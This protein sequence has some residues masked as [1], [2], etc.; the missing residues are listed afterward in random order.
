MIDDHV[1]GALS[2]RD[3]LRMIGHTVE[4]ANSGRAGIQT[5]GAFRPDVILCDIGLPGMDGYEVARA[6]RKDPARRETKLVALTGYAGPS[7]IAK[8]KKA[9]FG[10]HVAKPPSIEDLE[11][12]IS[13]P[14]GVR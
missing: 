4:V 5:A 13:G 11:K 7:D 9:G 1:D 12:V 3:M 2:L 8:A 6:L 14:I 10:D